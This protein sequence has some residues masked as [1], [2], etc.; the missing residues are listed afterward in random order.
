MPDHVSPSCVTRSTSNDLNSDTA[1]TLALNTRY[2]RGE[3]LESSLLSA[4]YADGLTAWHLAVMG[5]TTLEYDSSVCAV[6]R[7]VGSSILTYWV[8][9]VP[10]ERLPPCGRCQQV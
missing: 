3:A 6:S 7:G 8:A 9:A 2:L 10:G 1:Y 4:V 5:D